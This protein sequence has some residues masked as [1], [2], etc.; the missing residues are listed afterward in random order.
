MTLASSCA[1]WK[2]S[3]FIRVFRRKIGVLGFFFLKITTKFIEYLLYLQ[4]IR[5]I[6][7]SVGLNLIIGRERDDSLTSESSSENKFSLN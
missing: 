3:F 6:G 1:S 2:E 5:L 4:I 7:L